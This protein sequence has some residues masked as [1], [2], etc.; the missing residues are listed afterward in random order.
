MVV[1]RITLFNFKDEDIPAVKE[2][3]N[4]LEADNKKV[5]TPST[6]Q[7][8]ALKSPL[9]AQCIHSENYQVFPHCKSAIMMQQF[10]RSYDCLT[11]L[12]QLVQFNILQLHDMLGDQRAMKIET[13][14][15]E[16]I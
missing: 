14:T 5:S 4:Q 16:P 13:L 10:A 7:Q 15:M 1:K 8:V 9:G 12:L 6:A 3:Y 11:T 2:A